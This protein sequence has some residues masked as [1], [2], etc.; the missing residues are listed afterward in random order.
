MLFKFLWTEKCKD[1][2]TY[3]YCVWTHAQKSPVIDVPIAWTNFD[4]KW[5]E[6]STQVLSR[7]YKNCTKNIDQQ[8]CIQGIWIP[9]AT[10]LGVWAT[11]AWNKIYDDDESIIFTLSCRLVIK[12][13]QGDFIRY[14]IVCWTLLIGYVKMHIS[15]QHSNNV[16]TAG[17]QTWKATPKLS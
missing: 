2:Y 9:S 10:C 15:E 8:L 12:Q 5:A 16:Q 14:S 6:D 11:A 13:M 3:N 7:Y 4:L 17:D 1:H